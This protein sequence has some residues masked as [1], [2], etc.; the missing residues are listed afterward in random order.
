MRIPTFLLSFL[1]VLLAGTAIGQKS[2]IEGSISYTISSRTSPADELK[3]VGTYTVSFKD[4]MVRKDIKMNSGYTN[5][6]IV[7]GKNNSVYSLRTVAED[8]FAVQ[9]DYAEYLDRQK[10]YEGF[11]VAKRKTND[12]KAGFSATKGEVTYKDGTV[13]NI[14]FTEEVTI[15]EPK[16][17]ERL[18]GITYLPLAF[19]FQKETGPALHLELSNVEERPVESSLFTVPADFKIIT[20]KELKE[21]NK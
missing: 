10:K 16:L 13:T 6:I 9:M 4:G 1:L 11:T 15:S 14:Y 18:P 20:S 5:A 19:E 12:K 8:H 21:L 3:S 7:N 2:L 17:F